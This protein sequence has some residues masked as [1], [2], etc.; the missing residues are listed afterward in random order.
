MRA[1]TRSGQ[2][3]LTFETHAT[4]ITSTRRF[5][6]SD[7]TL[8][9]RAAPSNVLLSA[10]TATPSRRTIMKSEQLNELLL[11]SLEHEQ[12]GV[13]VYET[14][15][16]CAVM[17]EL[18]DEWEK[19]LE[20]TRHHVQVLTQ[21]LHEL[22]IDPEQATPGREI[23]GSMGSALVAAMQMA[24]ENG[25]REA[26]QLVAAECVV[27]AE[28]KDHLDWELIGQ[29]ANNA[30]ADI[31]DVLSEAYEEIEDEEDEHLYHSRGWCRELWLKSLG[32]QAVLPPPEERKHV[33]TAL[34]AA[35][36]ERASLQSR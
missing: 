8:R 20:Q 27:L 35:K 34:D 9:S 32:L 7:P 22:D 10:T 14:A 17:P 19:Y 30:G 13:K 23:V 4:A 21:V 25:D 31:A 18:A 1:L 29:V 3:P 5:D 36:V 6:D 28:T 16:K 24:L 2:T 15:I 12:G 11:Q 33:L 26:A